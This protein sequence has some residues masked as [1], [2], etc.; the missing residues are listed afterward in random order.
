MKRV[1]LCVLLITLLITAGC[2]GKTGSV[3][4]YIVDQHDQGIPGIKVHLG[5]NSIVT[6]SDGKFAFSSVPVGSY[7]VDAFAVG[8]T[9][10]HYMMAPITVTIKR[11]KNDL[12]RITAY[13]ILGVG[14]VIESIDDSI[15]TAA[16]SGCQ[17]VK[18]LLDREMVRFPSSNMK[19]RKAPTREASDALLAG[20]ISFFKITWEP[21]KETWVHHYRIDYVDDDVVTLVWDSQ[22]AHPEDPD[23][24]SAHPAAY[25][26]LD[27]ELVGIISS[28]GKYQFRITGLRADENQEKELPVIDASIG[29]FL[30]TFPTKLTKNGAQLSWTAVTGAS[31]YRVRVCS[32]VSLSEISEAWESGDELLAPE[33]TQV[34]PT[35]LT[36][37]NDYYWS[38]GDYANDGTGWTAEIALGRSGM[39]Y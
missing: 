8:G 24:D 4:G 19:S 35:G 15:T 12:G 31:G 30:D 39:T 33:T 21:L 18:T 23:F 28:A 27:N 16:V 20:N 17:R 25:L 26:D 6:G 37:E 7:E 11:G 2:M 13:E 34:T 14:V 38:V 10:G 36:A 9:V 5:T 32:D 29:M 3:S 22:D 1:A